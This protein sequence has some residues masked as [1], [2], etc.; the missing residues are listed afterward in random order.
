MPSVTII[1]FSGTEHVLDADPG[2]SLMELA[3]DHMVPGIEAECG[4]CCSCATCHCF[5]DEKWLDRTGRA[6][7]EEAELLSGTP[8]PQPNSRLACQITLTEEL[9]GLVVRLP[10]SQY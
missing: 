10:Q 3:V 9:D 6:S 8:D 1:E 4:G 2:L 7:G 5:V